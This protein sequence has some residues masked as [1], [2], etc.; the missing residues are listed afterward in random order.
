MLD[1]FVFNKSF[2]TLFNKRG[3]FAFLAGWC[4]LTF[5]NACFFNFRHDVIVVEAEWKTDF[6]LSICFRQLLWYSF[7]LVFLFLHW[8]WYNSFDDVISSG[9]S[10]RF[11]R[12][13]NSRFSNQLSFSWVLIIRLLAS[14]VA[15]SL[16]FVLLQAKNPKHHLTLIRLSWAILHYIIWFLSLSL[17][18]FRDDKKIRW[19]AVHDEC[20]FDYLF[21]D[22]YYPLRSILI[23]DII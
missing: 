2:G 13:L 7:R 15:A 3:D 19:E 14:Y 22:S 16:L 18:Y 11:R 5:A 21:S 23:T 17:W 12:V 20:Y 4:F 9:W 6:L 8:C 10:G 1:D